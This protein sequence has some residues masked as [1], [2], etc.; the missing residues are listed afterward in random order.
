MHLFEHWGGQHPQES[1]TLDYL[2]TTAAA[3]RQMIGVTE[4]STGLVYRGGSTW[5]DNLVPNFTYRASLSYVTGSHNLKVGFNRLHGFLRAR[6]YAFQPYSYRFN[7]GVPNQIT[8]FA[9]PYTTRNEVNNDLGLFAQDR[10]TV[11]RFTIT[12]ALRWDT[13]QTGF[14][15]Q[16]IG[17]GPLVPDRNLT[18]PAQRSL[19]WNDLT[20]RTGFAWDVHGDGRT[21]VKLTA[22]KY[23][24]AQTASGLGS[25]PNPFNTLVNQTTRSWTDDGR[26]GGIAGDF[27]PQCNLTL[28]AANGEC[29]AMANT[30]F[31]TAVPG[32]TFDPDLLTGYGVRGANLEFS[33]GVQHELLP[34]VSLDVAYFRRIYQNFTATDNLALDAND[35]DFFSITVPSDPRLPNGGGYTLE[36][37]RALKQSAFGRPSQN[38]NTVASRFGEQFEHWNGVDVNVRARTRNG[39]TLQLGSS[40]GRTWVDDCAVSQKLA[41]NNLSRPLQFCSS[42]TP[43]LTQV[44]GYATYT[45]PRIDVLTAVTYR[46]TPGAAINASFTAT[47][48]FLAANSTLGRALAGG[49]SNMSISLL[50]PDTRYLDRLTQVDLRFGKVL[51][52]GRTRASINLDLY[53]AVNAN[54]VLSVNETYAT[55]L[56]PTEVLKGRLAKVSFNFDF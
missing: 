1:Y 13:I 46:N 54:T 27:S 47:N 10:W 14:P 49:A 15:E 9:T 6:S 33:A 34:G 30:N 38:Y 21:A 56:A 50:E 40:T 36:G 48:A 4:Q 31:G 2:G 42:T 26:N 35:F 41:E 43:W 8:I 29:G 44:K 11:N 18:L 25:S 3:V 28:P 39:V 55:W 52:F 22:N 16:R 19:D 45:I 23:L 7:N 32:A 53:N 24:A 37:L 20:Y 51:R 17:P 12:G 5:G